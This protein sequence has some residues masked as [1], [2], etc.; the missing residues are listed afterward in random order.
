MQGKLFPWGWEKGLRLQES[1][2][3]VEYEMAK[4]CVE[5]GDLGWVFQVF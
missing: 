5:R 2:A 1:S 4:E 3:E